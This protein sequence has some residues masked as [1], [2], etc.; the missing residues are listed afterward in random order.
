M[1]VPASWLR[2]KPFEVAEGII[3]AMLYVWFAYRHTLAFQKTG[4]WSYPMMCL[5][6]MLTATFFIFRKSPVTVS[7]DQKDWFFAA[8]GTFSRFYSALLRGRSCQA[9]VPLSL[10][11]LCSKSLV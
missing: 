6:E 9:R 7:A 4:E 8:A 3:L 11:V 10:G 1:K 2:S 5:S